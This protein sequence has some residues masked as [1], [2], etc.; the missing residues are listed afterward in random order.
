M[1]KLCQHNNYSSSYV[2]WYQKRPTVLPGLTQLITACTITALSI[3]NL[4][5]QGNWRQKSYE[6][7][8]T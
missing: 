7:S 1:A 3:D 5:Q 8:L 4:W 2:D 6:M